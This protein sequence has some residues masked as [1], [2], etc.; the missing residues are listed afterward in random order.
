MEQSP[1]WEASSHS[2]SQIPHLLWTRRFITV[3]TTAHHWSLSWFG[4]IHSTP[5]Q[6][7]SLRSILILSSHLRVDLPSG[8]LCSGFQIRILYEFFFCPM[9]ATCH[10]HLILLDLIT[11]ITFGE[12]YKLWSSSLC[13]LLQPNATSSFLTSIRSPQHLLL[14]YT[15]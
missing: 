2:A 6:P 13:R 12:V 11:L 15:F 10:A 7:I 8:L 4:C 1:S 3:F 5:S 9:H 14:K